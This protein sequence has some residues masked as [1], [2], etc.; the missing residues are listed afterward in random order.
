MNGSASLKVPKVLSGQLCH[1]GAAMVVKSVGKSAWNRGNVW[2]RALV[3]GNGLMTPL[4]VLLAYAC[5]LGAHARG[6]S[7]DYS[8]LD[9]AA[10]SGYAFAWPALALWL[11]IAPADNLRSRLGRAAFCGAGLSI[12]FWVF[13]RSVDP[14]LTAPCGDP[15][16]IC[17]RWLSVYRLLAVVGGLGLVATVACARM[18]WMLGR[19]IANLSRATVGTRG[20]TL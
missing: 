19:R 14:A 10:V 15:S 2:L 11:S 18:I 13:V 7:A 17:E 8:E 1:G 4:L 5:L 20:G 12:V 16:V 9:G 3:L 6:A